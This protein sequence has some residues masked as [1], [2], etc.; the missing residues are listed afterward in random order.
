MLLRAR[1]GIK[2][3]SRFIQDVFFPQQ[4]DE[5]PGLDS[6]WGSSIEALCEPAPVPC[7]VPSSS[8]SVFRAFQISRIEVS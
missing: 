3:N 8:S 4:H 5:F 1:V 2:N 6:L 7:Y